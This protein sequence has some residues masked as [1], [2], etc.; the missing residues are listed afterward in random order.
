MGLGRVIKIFSLIVIIII[1]YTMYF[2]HVNGAMRLF[3]GLFFKRI[4]AIV[5]NRKSLRKEVSDLKTIHE[6]VV[7]LVAHSIVTLFAHYLA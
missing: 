2:Q 6:I 1:I 5:C 4:S 3:R 7:A